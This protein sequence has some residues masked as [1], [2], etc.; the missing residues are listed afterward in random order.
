MPNR[1]VMAPMGQGHAVGGVP[2]PGYPDYYRRRAEGG[3]GL[4]ISG[5]TA[6][7]HV[8]APLDA[9]EPHFHG[10]EPLAGW[11][12]AVDAVHGAGGRIIPQLWH[13]GLQ[14]LAFAPPAWP[15]FGPSGVW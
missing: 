8:G 12:R 3:A 1:V 15:M 5:A 9:N 14:G 11:K 4:I 13:A 6:I 10:E 2:D 7:P